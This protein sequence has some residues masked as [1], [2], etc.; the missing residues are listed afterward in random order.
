MVRRLRNFK[1]HFHSSSVPY[2]V[3]LVY[4]D[5]RKYC[6]VGCVGKKPD[7]LS[8]ESL[9]RYT[10]WKKQELSKKMV[11]WF[12]HT[13]QRIW[14]IHLHKIPNRSEAGNDKI[15]EAADEFNKEADLVMSR[16]RVLHIQESGETKRQR[17]EQREKEAAFQKRLRR[18][19]I[20]CLMLVTYIPSGTLRREIYSTLI[21]LMM[22]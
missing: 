22:V 12:R 2:E 16:K 21:Y 14:C 5:F 10:E 13:A 9:R 11:F 7:H 4:F 3:K 1:P 6:A 15:L 17:K 8:L 19:K 18:F 20:L